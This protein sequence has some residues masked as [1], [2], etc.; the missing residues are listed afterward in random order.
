M[1]KALKATFD[2]EDAKMVDLDESAE[3]MA[4]PL[5][6]RVAA[7]TSTPGNTDVADQLMD[8]EGEEEDEEMELDSDTD[9]ERDEEGDSDDDNDAENDASE[10]DASD[11]DD[12]EY[13][14]FQKPKDEQAEIGAEIR[15]LERCVPSLRED[16]KIVDRLGTGTFS[17]VYKAVDLHYHTKWDNSPWHGHHPPESSAHYQSRPYDPGSKVFVAIKR[18]Y[19]TSS[20]ERIR[21]EIEVLEATRGCRHVAQL[22]TAFR[23]EDQVVVIMPYQTNADFRVCK[24]LA[25]FF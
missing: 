2:D 19:V 18:I 6:Q 9:N 24:S 16:Y 5:V 3:D 21:N 25:P 20:P 8:V 7:E 12:E 4:L 10:A 11:E 23:K 1:Q 14:I 17:S 13:T 22:I 15:D